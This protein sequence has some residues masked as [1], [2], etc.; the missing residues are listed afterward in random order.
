MSVCGFVCARMC[1]PVHVCVCV[2]VY[3]FYVEIELKFVFMFKL[4]ILL[5][6]SLEFL[7]YESLIAPKSGLKFWPKSNSLIKM[8]ISIF[9]HIKK[10]NKE[11]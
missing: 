3:T 2:C 9:A 7:M 1:T 5:C 4:L 8:T 11:K 6:K 10:Q